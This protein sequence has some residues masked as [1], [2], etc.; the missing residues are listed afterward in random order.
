MAPLARNQAA[1]FAATAFSVARPI[2]PCA[3]F[4]LMADNQA[5]YHTY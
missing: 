1:S 5:V 2:L 4:I 3:P